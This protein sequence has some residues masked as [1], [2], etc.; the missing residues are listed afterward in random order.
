[1]RTTK[2]I[3]EELE[4]YEKE[5]QR[6]SDFMDNGGDPNSEFIYRNGKVSTGFSTWEEAL[7]SNVASM[8]TLKWV[9]NKL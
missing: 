4:Y 3:K 8:M 6:I 7:T 1:M 5:V 9:L 2:R